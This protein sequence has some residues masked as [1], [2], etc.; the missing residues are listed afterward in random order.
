MCK[1]ELAIFTI[2][3]IIC[4]VGIFVCCLLNMNFSYKNNKSDYQNIFKEVELLD[5]RNRFYGKFLIDIEFGKELE[6]KVIIIHH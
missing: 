4:F 6:K 5:Y 1:K 2:F 3:T